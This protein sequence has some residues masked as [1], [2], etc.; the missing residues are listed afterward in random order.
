MLFQTNKYHPDFQCVTKPYFRVSERGS[1]TV[2]NSFAKACLRT[3]NKSL[4][5]VHHTTATSSLPHHTDTLL[6]S[7]HGRDVF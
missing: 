1:H 2:K 3:I 6:P 7:P 4:L 5:S